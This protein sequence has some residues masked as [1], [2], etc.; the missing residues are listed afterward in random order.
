V[1]T[2]IV[3]FIAIGGYRVAPES[4]ATIRS[5]IRQYN[6]PKHSHGVRLNPDTASRIVW[7]SE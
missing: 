3:V 6:S 4:P 1:L 2:A 7:K 5:L